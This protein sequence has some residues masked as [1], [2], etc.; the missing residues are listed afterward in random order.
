MNALEPVQ[1]ADVMRRATANDSLR[2]DF[3]G[4][5]FGILSEHSG[6]SARFG[7]SF[8]IGSYGETVLRF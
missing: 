5:Q 3:M 8:E 6:A 7:A 4:R 1:R 2:S